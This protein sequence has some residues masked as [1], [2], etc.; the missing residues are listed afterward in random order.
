MNTIIQMTQNMYIFTSQ[1]ITLRGDVGDNKGK[2][3]IK[4]QSGHIL[5]P[6]GPILI[7]FMSILRLHICL[8]HWTFVSLSLWLLRRAEYW[9]D[10]KSFLYLD[11]LG[12]TDEVIHCGF[13]SGH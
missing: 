10:G 12:P 3:H 6:S 4:I 11:M 9:L 2:Y 1:N 7:N 8:I 5:T 13:Q